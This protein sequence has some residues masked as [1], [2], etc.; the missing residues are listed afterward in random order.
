MGG[1]GIG[2]GGDETLV[3]CSHS[4]AMSFVGIDRWRPITLH[5]R[6]VDSPTRPL[7]MISSEFAIH[8]GPCHQWIELAFGPRTR[9]HLGAPAAIRFSRR[10]SDRR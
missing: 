7:V 1:G 3:C 10:F 2:G 5:R 8:H 6:A 4:L 9:M